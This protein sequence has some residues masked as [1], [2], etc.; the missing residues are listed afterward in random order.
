MRKLAVLIPFVASLAGTAYADDDSPALTIYN[1]NFA[2]VKQE[3]ELSIH[4][5]VG[6]LRFADVAA[7]IDPTSVSFKSLTAPDKIAVLEQNYQYDLVTVAKLLRKYVDHQVTITTKE[8]GVYNGLLLSANNGDAVLKRADGS[9]IVLKSNTIFT[10]SFPSLPEGLITRPTLVWTLKNDA[11]EKQ[12]IEVAYLA[13][14]VNWHA[15]YVAVVDASDKKLELSGWVSIDNRSGVAYK[16]AK[17]KLVAGDV[18]R[19]VPRPSGVLV[20]AKAMDALNRVGAG[21]FKEKSFFEYHM[22]TLQRPATVANNE[23]KQISLFP[24]ANA[25]AAK[26]YVF[27]GA[28]Y[29]KKTRV[30]LE[31]ENGEAAGLGMPLPK[32]KIRVFKKDS[33]GSLEFVGEDLIDHTPKDEEVKVFLGNAFD[34]VG[35]R[36]R[37]SMREIAASAREEAFLIKIRNHKKEKVSVTVVEHPY[38]DW[39]ITKSSSKYIKKDAGT[40]EF[41]LE[42]QPG[43]EAEISY[44][45]LSKW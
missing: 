15:E 33:D 29:G 40:V 26:K 11:A 20:R 2:L 34:I 32:G 31:F 8:S 43:A 38:G 3:R 25:D 12:R 39:T 21:G 22:Y 35:E 36:V 27:D 6:E 16:D 5:G 42:V 45:L 19:V 28:R 41:N 10:V 9:V 18:N 44:T 17:L 23:T 7:T 13:N 30:Y 14:G 4:K 24:A 37:K 1:G